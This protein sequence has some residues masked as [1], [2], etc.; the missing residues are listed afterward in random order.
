MPSH[1]ERK[2]IDLPPEVTPLDVKGNDFADKQ[3]DLAA[4][5]HVINLNASSVVLNYSSLAQRIQKRNVCIMASF[6]A[7]KRGEVA[8]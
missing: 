3:A 4:E 1:S 6:D 8:D 5:E 2:G 7:R